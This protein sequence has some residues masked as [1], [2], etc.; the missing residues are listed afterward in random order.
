MGAQTQKKWGPEG[1]S[2]KGGAP[3]GGAPKGGAPKGGGP[4]F[5]AFFPSPTTSFALFVSH[6]VSSR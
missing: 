4:K 2:Q 6:C 5:R 1:W 3:K